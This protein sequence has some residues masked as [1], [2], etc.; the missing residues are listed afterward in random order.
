MTNKLGYKAETLTI[1][2]SNIQKFEL[3]ENRRKLRVPIVRKIELILANGKHFDS[4]LVIN[5]TKKSD[6]VLDGQHRTTAIN[7]VIAKDPN[8][9]IQCQLAVYDDLTLDEEREIF[10]MWNGGTKQSSDD[11]V[12]MFENEIPIL[13]M[14]QTSFPAPVSVYREANKVHFKLLTGAYSAARNHREGGYT[15]ANEDFVSMAQNLTE[16]D[17]ENL[18]KFFG[19]FLR[20]NKSVN[21]KMNIYM[22]TSPFNAIMYLYVNNVL[23]GNISAR[24]FWK[25]FKSRVVGNNDITRNVFS[26]GITATKL[27]QDQMFSAMNRG[28]KNLLFLPSDSDDTGD[29]EELDEEEEN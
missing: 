4:P 28:E 15:S 10:K 3:I 9:K 16:R 27:V 7:N 19:E 22:N 14:L 26:G 20:I 29:D 11:F 8:F 13:K 1:D 17:Y 2:S 21:K 23:A 24:D 25:R 18:S 6:R 12:A 5:R